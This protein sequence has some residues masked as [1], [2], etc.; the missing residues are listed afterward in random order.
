M[1]EESATSG[2]FSMSP[3]ST[4][5]FFISTTKYKTNKKNTHTKKKREQK[6]EKKKEKEKGKKYGENWQ[7]NHKSAAVSQRGDNATDSDVS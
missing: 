1:D 6:K 2:S 7:W 5:D 4:F 3:P